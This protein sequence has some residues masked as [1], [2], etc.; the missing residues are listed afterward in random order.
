MHVHIFIQSLLILQLTV[1]NFVEQKQQ[2][3]AKWK[4]IYSQ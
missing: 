3:Q 2:N 4:G 1:E